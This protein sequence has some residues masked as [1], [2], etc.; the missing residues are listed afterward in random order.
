MY[1]YYLLLL[2]ASRQVEHDKLVALFTIVIGKLASL[3]LESKVNGW[4]CNAKVL[5][6][7]F[8]QIPEYIFSLFSL[9][10]QWAF[11]S[12]ILIFFILASAI[13][14]LSTFAHTV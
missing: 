8:F 1:S 3:I 6:A 4:V 11:L 9:L 7:C 5:V 2:T 12:I 13:I 14:R 10:F